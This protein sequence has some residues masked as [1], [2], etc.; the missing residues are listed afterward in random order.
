MINPKTLWLAI[1][2]VEEHDG[3]TGIKHAILIL[4]DG[5]AAPGCFSAVNHCWLVWD[6]SEYYDEKPVCYID[7]NLVRTSQVSFKC[8]ERENP[9]DRK[10][11]VPLPFVKPKRAPGRPSLNPGLPR[12]V[13]G[14]YK[15][16]QVRARLRSVG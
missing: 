4:E 16:K 14:P 6:G 15:T 9:I 2:R 13:R 12:G 7:M 1:R 8:G 5:T 10:I 3:K 11:A